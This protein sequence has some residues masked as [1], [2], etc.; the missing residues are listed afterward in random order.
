MKLD[1]PAPQGRHFQC[2]GRYCP[3]RSNYSLRQHQRPYAFTLLFVGFLILAA[4]DVF[5]VL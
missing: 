3:D 4:G 1:L 5:R 2:R